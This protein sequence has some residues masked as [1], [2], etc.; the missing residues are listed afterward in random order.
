MENLRDLA[1]IVWLSNSRQRF[2]KYGASQNIFGKLRPIYVMFL[3]EEWKWDI[4]EHFRNTHLFRVI[5]LLELLFKH[6]LF[7]EARKD[8]TIKYTHML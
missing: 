2:R 5:G 1:P 3:E 4:Y 7:I 6:S 8:R